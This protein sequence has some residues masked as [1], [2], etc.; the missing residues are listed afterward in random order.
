M[1]RGVMSGPGPGRCPL[2][3]V[4]CREGAVRAE[5]SLIY[6]VKALLFV[7]LIEVV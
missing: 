2:H 3:A 4:K 6:V 1:C 5:A 7:I